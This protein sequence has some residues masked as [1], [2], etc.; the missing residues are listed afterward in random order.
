M[1]ADEL[2]AARERLGLSAQGFA[3]TFGVAD[4][5]TVRG[6]E[7]GQRNGHPHPVPGP[8]GLLVALALRFKEVRAFLKIEGH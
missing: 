7:A 8:I 1:T 6:W 4:G 5:R 3:D 2:K